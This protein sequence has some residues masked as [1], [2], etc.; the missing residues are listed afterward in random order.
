MIIN[1]TPKAQ[2]LFN[3][4]PKVADK[5]EA[6]AFAKANPLFSWHAN[7]LTLKRKKIVILM[8]DATYL[9]IV[10]VNVDA[11][12]KKILDVLIPM[13]I[14]TVFRTIGISEKQVREYFRVAGKIEVNAGHNRKVTDV[15]TNMITTS[16]PQLFDLERVV[17]INASLLLGNMIFQT[18][19]YQ[20]PIEKAQQAFSHSFRI[21]EVIPEETSEFTI[22]KKWQGFR[23]WPDRKVY[24]LNGKQIT[25]V[26]NNNELI[27]TDFK[28]YLE[29]KEQLAAKTVKKHTENIDLFLN[30]YAPY[31]L[32][33]TEI[34]ADDTVPL[35]YLDD[36]FSANVATSE[37]AVKQCGAAFKKFYRFLIF[38]GEIEES[39]WADI[40]DMIEIGV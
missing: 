10:L 13:A 5:K 20:S 36:W 29:E 8:N 38:M 25:A 26:L 22:T 17:D 30:E 37:T 19:D 34:V 23:E 2:V 14:E 6:Q 35:H 28:F 18:I 12:N 4:L 16:R 27:L 11:K 7:Y 40:R 3:Q 31:Y 21:N 32:S 1:P 9:P 39:A 15:L 33:M 24:D